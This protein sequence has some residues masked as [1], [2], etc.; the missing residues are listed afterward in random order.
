MVLVPY[1]Y[2]KTSGAR[3]ITPFTLDGAQYLAIPQLSKDESDTPANINGGQAKVDVLI[4][5]WVNGKLH[6]YQKILGHGNEGAAFFRIKDQAYLATTSIYSKPK[7]ANNKHSYSKLYRWDGHSFYPIQQFFTFAS[8]GVYAFSI[9]ERHFLAF[10]NGVVLPDNNITINTDSIVYEWNGKKFIP[11]QSFPTKW[12]YG[13]DFFT[14][15]GSHYLALTDHAKS[16]QIYRWNG[17]KFVLFQSFS[18]TGGRAFSHFTIDGKFY[19][20]YANLLHPSVIYQWAGNQFVEYQPLKGLGGRNFV[21]FVDHGNHYLFRVNFITGPRTKP[22]TKLSSQ[23]YQWINGKFQVVQNITTLGG[24]DAAVFSVNNQRYLGVANS[25]NEQARFQT[26]SVIYKINNPDYPS[27][28]YNLKQF[29]PKII[30]LS[31]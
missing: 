17:R 3:D 8:K 20:A 16:S 27:K 9:G 1:Q 28:K 5:R 22:K 15:N 11:F 10:A 18:K 26:D 24:V 13:W 12:A 31:S 19:L 14:I 2:L 29:L 4:F 6:L 25:L 30:K 7:T 23:L 21:Y